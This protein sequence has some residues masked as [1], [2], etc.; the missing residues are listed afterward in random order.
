[1]LDKK[2]AHKYSVET[3]IDLGNQIFN[4]RRDKKLSLSDLAND[5]GL[6]LERL[7]KVEL[8]RHISLDISFLQRLARFFHKKLKIT[9]ED[10]E[11]ENLTEQGDL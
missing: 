6:P 8:G 9:F 4:L 10:I 11:K 5:T 7:N 1:M 2:E 3:K